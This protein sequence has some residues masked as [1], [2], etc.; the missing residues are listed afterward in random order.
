LQTAQIYTHKHN[1]PTSCIEGERFCPQIIAHHF[2]R[3]FS[4][5]YSKLNNKLLESQKLQQEREAAGIEGGIDGASGTIVIGGRRL[6]AEANKKYV[7]LN[8]RSKKLT[9][10]TGEN[11]VQDKESIDDLFD[12]DRCFRKSS[13]PEKCE[14]SALID[15]GNSVKNSEVMVS[16]RQ[17]SSFS[18][19]PTISVESSSSV[20]VST[21]PPASSLEFQASASSSSVAAPSARSQSTSSKNVRP[22]FRDRIKYDE[23]V[24]NLTSVPLF[25]LAMRSDLAD[26]TRNVSSEAVI[27]TE[28]DIE[29]YGNSDCEWE[30]ESPGS[31]DD[32]AGSHKEDGLSHQDSPVANHSTGATASV[33]ADEDRHSAT[34]PFTP[35]GEML[36]SKP[37]SSMSASAASEILLRAVGTAN[38]MTDW[39]GRAVQKVLKQHLQLNNSKFSLQRP[40]EYF[41][42]V[43]STDGGRI[44]SS[45]RTES[46]VS[47]RYRS[48]APYD[49]PCTINEY[50][51]IRRIEANERSNVESSNEGSVVFVDLC[52]PSSTEG[53]DDVDEGARMVAKS[54]LPAEKKSSVHFWDE[55]DE[56]MYVSDSEAEDASVAGDEAEERVARSFPAV[57]RLIAVDSSPAVPV[58]SETDPPADINFVPPSD[59]LLA[60][61]ESDRHTA[62]GRSSHIAEQPLQVVTGSVYSSSEQFPR[63]AVE[64]IKGVVAAAGAGSSDLV[65]SRKLLVSE[66]VLEASLRKAKSRSSRDADTM[67]EEMKDDIMQLLNAF[68]LP[69]V[70]APFEAEAQCAALE[71]VRFKQIW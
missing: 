22:D 66:Q 68:G 6:A 33:E 37:T 18:D 59:T 44:E 62:V 32:V 3:Y 65:N 64:A 11:L 23:V 48:P 39:A 28:D 50:D 1:S 35:T 52:G 19:L 42:S 41:Q 47:G 10:G 60:S 29:F 31:N 24:S 45:P 13:A 5:C 20:S 26:D 63:A 14:T 30:S 56:M 27:S 17:T 53:V 67:T 55:R 58:T 61:L 25:S 40:E 43:G 21:F 71:L 38:S 69:Y 34:V 9:G 51:M 15:V 54:S 12:Y 8:K 70:V 57:E 46:P 49:D 16:G 7:L 4:Y 36:V 2:S